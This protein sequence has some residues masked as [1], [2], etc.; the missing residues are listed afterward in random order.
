MHGTAV[1]AEATVA[2]RVGEAEIHAKCMGRKWRVLLCPQG[3]PEVPCSEVRKL[4]FLVY[5][6]DSSLIQ[7]FHEVTPQKEPFL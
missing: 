3:T 7:H 4:L 5:F 6:L 1:A 2:G